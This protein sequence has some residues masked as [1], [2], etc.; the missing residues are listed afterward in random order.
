DAGATWRRV[1]EAKGLVGAYFARL[2]PDPKN[3]DVVWA[4]GQSLRRST[5][6]GTTFTEV[7]GSPGGD[8]Y[9]FLWIDPER[10]ERMIAAS[11]QGTVVTVNG[12]T[13]WSSW[14]NQPTGQFYHLATDDRFPYRIYSG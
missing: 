3:P 1:N 12:G 2:T 6:G 13:S 8:D 5:D 9:H 11:D 7:R 14:Y 10:P 4:M